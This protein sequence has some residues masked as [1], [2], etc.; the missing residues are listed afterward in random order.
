MVKFFSLVDSE[1]GAGA[2]SGNEPH[3]PLRCFTIKISIWCLS[4][5]V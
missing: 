5:G 2:G 4:D 3:K 1:A